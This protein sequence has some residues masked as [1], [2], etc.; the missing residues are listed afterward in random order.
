MRKQRCKQIELRPELFWMEK[1]L[2]RK[3]RCKQVTVSRALEISRTFSTHVT[4]KPE[5]RPESDMLDQRSWDRSR[6]KGK[7]LGGTHLASG[8][9]RLALHLLISVVTVSTERVLS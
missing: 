2:M 5:L 3:Q 9:Q 8:N 4:N 1:V 6:D 7:P